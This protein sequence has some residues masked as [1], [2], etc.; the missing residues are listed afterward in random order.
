MSVLILSAGVGAVLGAALGYFGQCSSGTCPLTSSWWRGSLYGAAL[1]ALFGLGS[2]RSDGSWGLGAHRDSTNVVHVAEK[3]F[4]ARVVQATQPVLV[5]FYATWC[6][7]CNDLAPTIAKLADQYA[8]RAVVAKVNIDEAPHLSEKY[9]VEAIPAL[10][11]FQNGKVVR[12]SVGIV[13]EKELRRQ[14]DDLIGNSERTAR[15]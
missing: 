1:G 10:F 3:D 15:K 12:S 13:A 8:G 2:G 14:I 7:P 11:F 5:D 4:E 6:G 9:Q